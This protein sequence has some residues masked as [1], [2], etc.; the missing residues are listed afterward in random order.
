MIISIAAEKAFN[1]IQHVFKDLKKK[2]TRTKVVIEGI[3]VST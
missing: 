2:K 1:K 3:Q